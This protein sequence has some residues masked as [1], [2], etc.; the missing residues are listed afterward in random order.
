MYLQDVCTIPI[1]LAGV[2]AISVPC[3]FSNE[4][5]VGLQIIAKPLDEATLIRT[6]YTFEQNNEYHKSIAPVGEAK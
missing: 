4:L 6:A 5:P 1:N 2:P 3:G